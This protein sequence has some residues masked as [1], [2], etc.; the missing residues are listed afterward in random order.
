TS[1]NFLNQIS[2]DQEIELIEKE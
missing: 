2:K 1:S